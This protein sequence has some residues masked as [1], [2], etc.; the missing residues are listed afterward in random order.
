ME[1][2]ALNKDR[3]LIKPDAPNNLNEYIDMVDTM[4][5]TINAVGGKWLLNIQMKNL[6]AGGSSSSSVAGKQNPNYIKW[7]EY[8]FG[9]RKK[10][11]ETFKDDEREY[12]RPIADDIEIFKKNKGLCAAIFIARQVTQLSVCDLVHFFPGCSEA[13]LQHIIT[14]VNDERIKDK[15][16][17]IA[18]HRLKNT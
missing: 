6:S 13:S 12:D 14:Y 11:A 10:T 8:V 7:K 17:G 5:A 15:L 16:F 3:A 9:I 1:L 2:D 4:T 18:L